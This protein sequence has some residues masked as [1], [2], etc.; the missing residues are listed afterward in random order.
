MQ[1][2]G[3]KQHFILGYI[4]ITK[5]VHILL[6]WRLHVKLFESSLVGLMCRL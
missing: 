4:Q 1:G 3:F 6:T 5:D 2:E